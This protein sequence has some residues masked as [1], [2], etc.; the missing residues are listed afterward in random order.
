[1]RIQN[2]NAAASLGI[3]GKVKIGDKAKNQNG[4]EY[5]VSL[6]YF[7]F[8]SNEE[9]RIK[10]MAEMFGE[11]PTKLPITFH[12]DDAN[13][14]CVQRYEI[15]DSGGKLV[16]YGD[17]VNFWESHK[18][19][20]IQ[21]PTMTVQQGEAY[22]KQVAGNTKAEWQETLTLRF[23]VLQYP[24]LGLW[25]FS[26]KGKDTSIGQIISAFD[27]VMERAGRVKGI[28]FWLTVEKHKS[29][30]ANA[31]RQY[32]VANLVCDLSPEMV[33]TVYSLGDNIRGLI[34]PEKLNVSAL[35]SGIVGA[36]NQ[37]P[38]VEDDEEVEFEEVPP[39]EE[40]PALQNPLV[41]QTIEMLDLEPDTEGEPMPHNIPGNDWREDEKWELIE[42]TDKRYASV[43]EWIIS[44]GATR[45][46][47][48]DFQESKQVRFGA[49]RNHLENLIWYREEMLKGK[50][51][52]FDL[53]SILGQNETT[54]AEKV[55]WKAL[56]AEKKLK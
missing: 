19:G 7:R 44:K 21:K 29:N 11:K 5:P 3:L 48:N 43:V 32:P 9:M 53:K 51:G 24:E 39:N 35:P 31:N 54:E 22:M 42:D 37:T 41:V 47:L 30:R 14:C 2:R 46:K 40:Q 16:A 28:P 49:K 27:T 34:T 8:T 25:E 4:K 52:A 17:G 36:V 1:M 33:E 38:P 6:D 50:S 18:D 55:L 26:T 10:R 45:E 12:A 15:R 56:A 23:M 20:F 13:V